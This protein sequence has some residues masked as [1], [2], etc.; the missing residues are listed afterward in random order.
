MI[1]KDFIG[2]RL[3]KKRFGWVAKEQKPKNERKTES[4]KKRLCQLSAW[5][6]NLN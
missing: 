5:F 6:L 2:R 1:C 3:T 4:N